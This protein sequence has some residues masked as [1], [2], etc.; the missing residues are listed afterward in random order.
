MTGS[1][2]VAGD[3]AS[4]DAAAFKLR[5]AARLGVRPEDIVLSVAPASVVITYTVVF[6]SEQSAADGASALSSSSPTDL[7]SDLGLSVESVGAVRLAATAIEAPSPPPPSPPPS[8]PPVPPSFPATPS[9]PSPPSPS[10]PPP[11]NQPLAP[12][13]VPASP[14]LVD[15]GADAIARATA[16]SIGSTELAL[17]GIASGSGGAAIFCCCVL[18]VLLASIRK[19]RQKEKKRAEE[20]LRVSA[21]SPFSSI[22]AFSTVSQLPP[23]ERAHP[24]PCS[25]S[26]RSTY[27]TTGVPSSPVSL[28]CHSPGSTRG[29]RRDLDLPMQFTE[30]EMEELGITAADLEPASV[31]ALV[32]S[33]VRRAVWGAPPTN[34]EVTPPRLRPESVEVAERVA[35]ARKL[36]PDAHSPPDLGAATAGT[37]RAASTRVE[38]P[39]VVASQAAWLRREAKETPGTGHSSVSPEDSIGR[40]VRR[41]SH[42]GAV[43]EGGAPRR[44]ASQR[45][46]IHRSPE[47]AERVARARS[48]TQW[49]NPDADLH[50]P[51]SPLST[52]LSP[53]SQLWG[54]REVPP[55]LNL[56]RT[57]DEIPLAAG[58]HLPPPPLPTP[59]PLPPPLPPPPLPT[60]PSFSAHTSE[61]LVRPSEVRSSERRRI[62]TWPPPEHG[63]APEHR[64]SVASFYREEEQSSQHS[65]GISPRESEAIRE[66]RNTMRVGWQQRSE[67]AE[68]S[69]HAQSAVV[70]RQT[71]RPTKV[72]STLDTSAPHATY[73]QRPIRSTEGRPRRAAPTRSSEGSDHGSEASADRTILAS[74]VQLAS[75]STVPSPNRIDP[76]RVVVEASASRRSD[77]HGELSASDGEDA[78]GGDAVALRCPGSQVSQAAESTNALSS[79]ACA[80]VVHA[81]ASCGSLGS[82]SPS[83]AL[84][85]CRAALNA[86]RD[87]AASPAANSGSDIVI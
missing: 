10:P 48:S 15:G 82:A 20:G 7:S 57:V 78:N 6:P 43:H 38:T 59:P 68:R 9:P 33:A 74:N 13:P 8:P 49:L 21:S 12:S 37:A 1:M 53:A 2:T 62:P 65:S 3:V 25:P 27:S 23:S 70:K 19:R 31:S 42:G 45:S 17:I 64:V 73:P 66:L 50:S 69:G 58:A 26:A 41:M 22:E 51:Q 60:P 39:D 29:R 35:R 24:D 36:N 4:F 54:L 72:D 32:E 79:A 52:A 67:Q 47:I 34:G 77:E 40:N 56:P 76:Q 11:L 75:F 30:E 5:L 83:S 80:S 84:H 87:A 63:G 14:L 16:S 55:A 86:V 81:A 28:A 61:D 71:S 46:T 85:R 18:V 44:G